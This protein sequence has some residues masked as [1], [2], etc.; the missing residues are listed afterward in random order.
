ME[1]LPDAVFV[2]DLKTEEIAV[3]EA[4]PAADPDHRP[5]RHQRRSGGRRLLIP[6]NDDAI[7]SCELVIG[8]IGAAID[9]GAGAWRVEEERRRAEEE[10]RRR[11]EAEERRKREEEEKAR[12][13]A[14]EAAAKA[15]AEAEAA[16]AAE[17]AQPGGSSAAAAGRVDRGGGAGRERRRERGL[18]AVSAA[19]VKA[20]RDRTGAGMMDCKAALAEADGDLD[21]RHRDPAGQGPGLGREARAA[22]AP[23]EGVVSSYIHANR[24]GRG[25]GR[26]PVRDRLRRPQRGLPGVRPRGRDPRRRHRPAIR[27]LRGDPGGRARGGAAGLR[28]EGAR[29]GQARERRR[30]DRR[31][32][33]GEVGRARWPCSSR[34]T[35]APRSYDGKTIEQLRAELAAKTGENIRIA[36]F[37]Y[38]ASA[39]S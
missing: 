34:S 20:L 23:S 4:D 1:R 26:G 37:A 2:I 5:G 11:I 29:G 19:D 17:A 39:R 10:E 18:M 31:G 12:Q 30:E 21:K 7:R 36:R 27:L 6:G 24:Q 15:T 22:A 13:E 28:A 38:F 16:G 25:D 32:P 8:T 33:A 14:E 3:A 9:E 35:S